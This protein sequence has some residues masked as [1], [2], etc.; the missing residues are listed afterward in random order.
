MRGTNGRFLKGASGNPGGGPKGP[1]VLSQM[2]DL[3]AET[4][5]DGERSKLRA[6]LDL[7]YDQAMAGEAAQQKLILERVCPAKLAV[8]ASMAEDLRVTIVR[9]FTRGNSAPPPVTGETFG[10]WQQRVGRQWFERAALEVQPQPV[11]SRPGLAPI[12]RRESGPPPPPEPQAPAV[13]S[14]T[15]SAD[16]LGD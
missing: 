10:Q 16:D 12:L 7:V 1:S 13:R 4:S 15:P 9:D 8:E 3:L 14:W 2:R 6:L 11:L 5:A